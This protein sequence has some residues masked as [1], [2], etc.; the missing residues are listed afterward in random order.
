M[1]SVGVCMYICPSWCDWYVKHVLAVVC[2]VATHVVV[3]A[4]VVCTPVHVVW[5]R[6]FYVPYFA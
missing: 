3:S 5:M 4:P 1:V 2:Y 6:K